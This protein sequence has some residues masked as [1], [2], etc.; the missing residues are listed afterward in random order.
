MITVGPDFRPPPQIGVF[1]LVFV[2]LALQTLLLEEQEFGGD[3]V[4]TSWYRSPERNELVGGVPDSLHQVG[5]AWDIADED[6]SVG[7]V[8]RGAACGLGSFVGLC[9]PRPLFSLQR[10]FLGMAPPF[11]QALR[12]DDHTHL[13]LDLTP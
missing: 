6:L 10:R 3:H 13:E 9:T 4:I 5:L 12:E 11:T 7:N 2:Y 8:L 1:Q